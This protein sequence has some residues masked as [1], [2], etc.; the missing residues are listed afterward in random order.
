ML[1]SWGYL[2]DRFAQ[3]WLFAGTLTNLVVLVM[4]VVA[5]LIVAAQGDL[6]TGLV[7]F[8]AI[9]LVVSVV[10]WC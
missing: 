2:T 9:G 8:A 10:V 1:R 7:V 5:V 4:P 6:R 3:S